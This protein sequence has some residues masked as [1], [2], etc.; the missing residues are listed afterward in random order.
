MHSSEKINE[1]VNYLMPSLRGIHWRPVVIVGAPESGKTNLA[2]YLAQRLIEKFGEDKVNLIYVRFF[3]NALSFFNKKQYQIIIV[4]DAVRYQYSRFGMTSEGISTIADYY[5]IRHILRRKSGIS[6]AG[7]LIFFITQRYRALSTDLRNAPLIFFKSLLTDYYEL[8][9]LRKTLRPEYYRILVNITKRIYG[10]GEEAAKGEF[11]AITAWGSQ[12]YVRGIPKVKIDMKPMDED[13][14]D[15]VEIALKKVLEEFGDDILNIPDQVIKGY[16]TKL[17]KEFGTKLPGNIA[18]LAKY[19]AFKRTKRIEKT[20]KI[21]DKINGEIPKIWHQL[22]KS[23]KIGLIL[24]KNPDLSIKD[25]V[26]IMHILD[27]RFH[28]H[29]QDGRLELDELDKRILSLRIAG[30][31]QEKI[32]DILGINRSTVAKRLIKIRNKLGYN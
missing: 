15:I 31:K 10:L 22:S 14:E 6:K 7:I 9:Y 21:I 20:P 24:D 26:K 8:E 27:Y 32:A 5:E 13:A 29:K 3:R 18:Y 12:Y 19:E 4:D 2:F 23:E 17:E 25:A 28:N 1:I 16:I 30:K 11:I